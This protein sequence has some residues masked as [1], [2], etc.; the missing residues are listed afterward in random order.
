MVAAGGSVRVMM[1]VEERE[2]RRKGVEARG[3]AISKWEEPS[4]GRLDI[5]DRA[6][7]QGAWYLSPDQDGSPGLNCAAA[8]LRK[9][10]TKGGSQ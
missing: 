3:K 10:Q 7:R 5:L 1:S 2:K 9:V 4:H 8:W 6:E